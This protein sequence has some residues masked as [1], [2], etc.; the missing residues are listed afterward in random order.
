MFRKRINTAPYEIYAKFDSVCHES[1]KA[2]RKGDKCVYYPSTK[3]VFHNDSKQASEFR[4]W[5]F[6][7]NILGHN[8]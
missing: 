2:I 7:C 1:G 3:K 6:D 8:Y 4:S 5:N